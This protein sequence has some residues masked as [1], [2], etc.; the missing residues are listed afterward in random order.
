MTPNDTPASQAAAPDW[1]SMVDTELVSIGKLMPA[2]GLSS[3]EAQVFIHVKLARGLL[4][5]S[6]TVAA[7]P[8]PHAAKATVRYKELLDEYKTFLFGKHTAWT[9]GDERYAEDLT[10]FEAR[11]VA[12]NNLAA[13]AMGEEILSLRAQLAAA[14]AAL[15]EAQKE[16]DDLKLYAG[17]LEDQLDGYGLEMACKKYDTAA[18][19]RR[20]G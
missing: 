18:S 1:L 14:E 10:D 6:A 15:R 17:C 3:V 2:T 4:R 9:M 13:I 7:A 16:F 19:A 5:E 20:E 12:K 8:T 11:A